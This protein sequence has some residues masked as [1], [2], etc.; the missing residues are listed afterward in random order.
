MASL[1]SLLDIWGAFHG[2]TVRILSPALGLDN[3]G[4]RVASLRAGRSC[5]LM[6]YIQESSS[7]QILLKL[8][9]EIKVLLQ[10]LDQTLYS[11]VPPPNLPWNH[12][13]KV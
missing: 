3:L 7:V 1:T 4:F 6:R 8:D 5:S 11:V 9:S 2:W 12:F 13:F 10:W